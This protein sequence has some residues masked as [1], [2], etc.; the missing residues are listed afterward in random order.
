M[1]AVAWA[2]GEE[3][4]SGTTAD[5]LSPQGETTRAQTAALLHRFM[6]YLD[7]ER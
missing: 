2:V 1:D 3:L 5:T 4:I 7:I 6:T